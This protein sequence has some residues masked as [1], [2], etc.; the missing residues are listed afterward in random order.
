MT[1]AP[2]ALAALEPRLASAPGTVSVYYGPLDGPP[3]YQRLAD[4]PHYAA[5]TMKASVLAGAY[6]MAD[7]GRLDLDERVE[8]HADFASAGDGSRF[9]MNHGY[10]NDDEVWALLGDTAPLRWLARRM[11]VRSSNLATNLV[12]ERVGAEEIARVWADAGATTSVVGRG[13]E[14]QAAEQAGISNRVTAA[15]LARLLSSIATNTIASAPACAEMMEVLLAQEGTEDLAA[16]LPPGTR[17]AH[18]N[19]WV[20]RIRHGVGV[21]LPD[22]AAPYVVAVCTTSDL[23]D[24]LACRLVADVSAAAWAGRRAL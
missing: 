2:S 23:R 19:G 11:I 20:N 4:E 17:I 6:R 18:K 3:A 16:G 15:D 22:D 10:D 5:S 9:T 13:I 14:D 21:V 24:D 8:V 12:M 1:T 7:V